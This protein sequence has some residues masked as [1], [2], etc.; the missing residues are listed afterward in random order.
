MYHFKQN[1]F[2]VTFPSLKILASYIPSILH[3]NKRRKKWKLTCSVC[4]FWL[5]LLRGSFQ[6]LKFFEALDQEFEILCYFTLKKFISLGRSSQ[7]SLLNTPFAFKEHK[8]LRNIFENQRKISETSTEPYQFPNECS[9]CTANL[10][11][12]ILSF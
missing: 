12:S 7:N 2:L 8:V 5:N 4:K 10:L 1:G 9:R 6:N 3:N 11:C